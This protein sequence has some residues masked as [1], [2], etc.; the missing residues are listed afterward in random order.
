[1]TRRP[2]S[3]DDF[4]V[5][6]IC[7]LKVEYDAV[8][9]L[10]DWWG[11]GNR[12]GAAAEDDNTYKT[13]RMG[14]VN[15]VL[16]RLSGI[17]KSI[18][19]AAAACLR[20]SFPKLK[21]VLLTGIV[22]V[23]PSTT[24]DRDMLLGDVTISNSVVQYDLGRQYPDGFEVRHHVGDRFVDMTKS[25]RSL[26]ATLEADHWRECLEDQT[27]GFLEQL[28]K[29]ASFN[30]QQVEY[31]YPG[32]ANDRLFEPG[33]R[34]KHQPSIPHA[35]AEYRESS[36]SACEKSRELTCEELGCSDNSTVWRNR[37]E[38]KWGLEKD[39][40]TDEAQAPL[41]FFGRFASGDTVM[42]SAEHRDKIAKRHG[43]MAFEME[44]AGV[45]EQQLPCMIVKGACDYADSHKNKA[46][47]RFAAATAASAARALIILEFR[48][49]FPGSR[50]PTR[51]GRRFSTLR[52][53]D[54]SR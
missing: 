19:A 31:K 6:I 23:Q 54:F 32:T 48:G 27:A 33:Y 20:L 15:V 40:L 14:D 17:G 8:S 47:H 38:S 45:W 12:Y 21:L 43:V 51:R 35:Y 49:W 7:A 25:I 1:M 10:V 34:H 22:V 3:R 36:D 29:M 5:A 46:W 53:Q 13:G 28:Q 18:S 26:V 42:K 24:M 16:V 37:L 30:G 39:E 44:G 4:P 11:N 9:L 50:G 2:A 52:S 41:V